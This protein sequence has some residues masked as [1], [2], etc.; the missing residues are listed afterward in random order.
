MGEI[1]M[2]HSSVEWFDDGIVK[3]GCLCVGDVVKTVICHFC[4]FVVGVGYVVL[5]YVVLCRFLRRF[6][7]LTWGCHR[8]S[9]K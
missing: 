7:S 5:N 2:F 9:H 4:F 8:T 1:C 6:F 3:C